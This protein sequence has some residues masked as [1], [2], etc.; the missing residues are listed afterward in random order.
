MLI[1][2]LLGGG[3]VLLFGLIMRIFK[4][5]WLIAGY[6]TASKEKIAKYN[7]AQLTRF[8]GNMLIAASVIL[9]IGGLLSAFVSLSLFIV[10]ISWG[11]STAVILGGVVYMNTGNRFKN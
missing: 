5:G 11:L 6:N 4:A 8:V 2:N 9:F 10:K 7:E 3:I 1:K